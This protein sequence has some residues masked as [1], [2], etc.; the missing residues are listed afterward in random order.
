MIS[1]IGMGE[2]EK[3][4]VSLGLLFSAC[5]ANQGGASETKATTNVEDLEDNSD[6]RSPTG[7][8]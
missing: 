5:L 2:E 7:V 8:P 1:V 3:H 6:Q 4:Q